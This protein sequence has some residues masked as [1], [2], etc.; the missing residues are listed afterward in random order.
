MTASQEMFTPP[1][2]DILRVFQVNGIPQRLMGGEGKSYKV[3]SIVFKPII[4]T[5]ESIWRAELMS[6]LPQ[7]GYRLAT[8]VRTVD[9]EW[10]YN[11]WEASKFL[12][13]SETTKRAK[14]KV[15]ICRLFHTALQGFSRPDFIDAATHPWAV[16]DRMVWGEQK[17][18]YGERLAHTAGP[19]INMLKPIALPNQLIHGDICGNIL[20]HPD[21]DPA[22]ID[23]SLYWRPADFA[24]AVLIVDSIVWNSENPSLLDLMENSIQM[25]QLL[26]R[27]ALWRI[28]TT[29][30]SVKQNG[31]GDI[32]DV[33]AFLPLIEVLKS[34]NTI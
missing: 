13:G 27:A 26:V 17:L 24:T 1:S 12:E 20:F 33:D 9:G 25:H 11:G 4:T 2:P 19:L 34:R 29:E 28:K 7:K 22:I 5:E 32:Q 10:V 18:E 15:A 14:E 3:G 8:P 30:E 23:L 16:A 31:R 6:S 21:L